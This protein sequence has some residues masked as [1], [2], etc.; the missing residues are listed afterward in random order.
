MGESPTLPEATA[1]FDAFT[2]VTTWYAQNETTLELEEVPMSMS[3]ISTFWFENMHL[4]LVYGAQLG[5]ASLMLLVLLLLTQPGKRRAPIYILNTVTLVLD[6]IRSALMAH[7]LTSIWNHPVVQLLGDYS[8]LSRGDYA[9]SVLVNVVKTIEL[10]VVLSSLLLQVRVILTTATSAQRAV[11]L[12]VAFV[13]GMVTL[14]VQLASTVVNSRNIV[15]LTQTEDFSLQIRLANLS[16]ILQLVSTS[17]FML[18]FATKLGFA[19]KQRYKLGN[20]RFGPM[21]MV[22]IGSLQSMLIPGLFSPFHLRF[23]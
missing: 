15:R 20:S 18:V 10:A 23:V 21:Q 22:F 11:I 8:R 1:L 12:S 19:I 13:L 17:F 9:A 6:L 5:L 2:Q 16:R 4:G 14:C 3:D 7:W